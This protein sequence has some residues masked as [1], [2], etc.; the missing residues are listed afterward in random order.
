[1]RDNHESV[2][3]DTPGTAGTVIRPP[4]AGSGL[5]GLVT[6]TVGRVHGGP[7]HPPNPVGGTA[8]VA[9]IL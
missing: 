9:A 7:P 4:G 1:V 2:I 6:R 5:T 3:H 8:P